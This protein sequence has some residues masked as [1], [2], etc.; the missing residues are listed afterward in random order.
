MYPIDLK[1][2]R[3]KIFESCYHLFHKEKLKNRMQNFIKIIRNNHRFTKQDTP[4]FQRFSY[5][6]KQSRRVHRKISTW[7]RLDVFFPVSCPFL[8]FGST[9]EGARFIK[10]GLMI[11]SAK[12]GSKTNRYYHY[13]QLLFFAQL[14]PSFNARWLYVFVVMISSNSNN[15]EH[16]IPDYF[17]GLWNSKWY[18]FVPVLTVEAA[19]HQTLLKRYGLLIRQCSSMFTP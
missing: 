12:G 17:G 5:A 9:V 13:P 14:H 8:S 11:L 6:L 3:L 7:T 2:Y 18:K 10:G 16:S 1:N 19:K 15:W 4:F